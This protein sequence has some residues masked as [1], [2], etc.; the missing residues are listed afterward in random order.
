MPNNPA[1]GDAKQVINRITLFTKATVLCAIFISFFLFYRGVFTSNSTPVF[2]SVAVLVFVLVSCRLLEMLSN[3]KV[4]K[5][6]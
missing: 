3:D 4:K 5:V 2:V 1:V 6:Q